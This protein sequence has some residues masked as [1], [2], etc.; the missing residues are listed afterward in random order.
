MKITKH[1]HTLPEST[2]PLT[3][4]DTFAPVEF[5]IT[6][7]DMEELKTLWATLN[8]SDTQVLKNGKHIK[9]LPE[10]TCNFLRLFREVDDSY[11]TNKKLLKQH[12]KLCKANKSK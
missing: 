10:E 6:I 8:A 12:K 5:T 2:L 9:L 1:Q 11:K 3:L 4:R 7:E